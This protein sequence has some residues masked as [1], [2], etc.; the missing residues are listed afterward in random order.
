MMISITSDDFRQAFVVSKNEIRKFVRG[1]RFALYVLLVAAIFAMLTTFP[2]LFG[3]G[4]GSTSGDVISQYISFVYM[5]VVLAA[6]LF[7]SVVIVSEF[8]ERTAL[9]MFTRPIRKTSIFLGKVLACIFLES[10]MIIA[11]YIGIA[12]VSLA[13][14]GTVASSLAVSLGISLLYVLATSSVAVFISS[15]VKKGSTSAIMT[16][17]FLLLILPVITMVTGADS[18]YM[19]NI[20]SESISTCIPEYL[21]SYNLVVTQMEDLSGVSFEFMKKVA[22]EIMRTV[23]TMMAWTAPMVAAW[24]IFVKRG[25]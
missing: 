22:P 3:D 24:A 2:Y 20:V 6:T 4:L 15:I 21:D 8:E 9:L 13:V 23:G 14:A 17:V 1:K 10:V 18:W 12:V 5:L 19:L 25:I 16:F 7:A 11:F